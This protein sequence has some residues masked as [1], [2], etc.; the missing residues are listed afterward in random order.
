MKKIGKSIIVFALGLSVFSTWANEPAFVGVRPL[1]LIDDMYE[2][3]LKTKLSQ[4]SEGPFQRSN[5]SIAHRGA[6]MQFPEHT[7]ESY[8]AAIRSGAGIVECDVSFT[9]DKQLVCR[10]SQSDLHTTTDVLAHPDLAAKCTTPFI[11]ADPA[12][13][14]KAQAEC[15][16]S[17]FTLDEFKTLKG[18]MDG[19]NPMATSVEEYMLGTP[20]WRTDLYAARGTLMTHAESAALF[21][22]HGVKV[23]P[24]LKSTVLEMPYNG[25]TQEMY[26]QKLIAELKDA[27]FTASDSYLQSFNIDDIKYWIANNPKF[28]KQAIFLDGR[29]YEDKNFKPSFKNMKS[30]ADAGVQIIAPPIY[31]LVT[32]D[33]KGAI[34]PSDYAKYAKLAGLDII[35]WSLE[36]SGPLA[37]GGGWYYQSVTNAI[38]R[39]GDTM[40]VLDVLAKQ[41]GVIGVFSDWPAT[42][43]Y[44]AN[45]MGIK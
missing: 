22:A 44:Y 21:K 4:C 34:V 43:T 40:V 19:S 31:A 36:R 27:G 12:N 15:R 2:S 20:S 7:K 17:D 6:P 18:K 28:A 32:L 24:E 30:L 37:Q 45:C 14:K 39:D 3:P 35:T 38:K 26:A 16:T 29:M 9:K 25:F 11:P 41:V 5:F 23:A 42:V 33:S 10:H 1:F 13:G 8:L